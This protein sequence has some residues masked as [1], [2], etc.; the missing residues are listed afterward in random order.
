MSSDDD[1]VVHDVH[2]AGHQG[3]GAQ[4]ARRGVPVLRHGAG[5]ARRA[6]LRHGVRHDGT[7][8]CGVIGSP[9]NVI[10][11]WVCKR[12]LTEHWRDHPAA[13]ICAHDSCHLL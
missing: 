11:Y 9:V 2:G 4:P 3:Q 8:V 13:C 6:R 12:S 1:V 7:H 5:A 10:D